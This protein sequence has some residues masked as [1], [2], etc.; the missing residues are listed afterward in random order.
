MPRGS[1][2]G[3]RRGGRHR[4][5]PNKRTVL[6]DRIL[7]AASTHPSASWHELLA[8][9]VK[10]QA[11][12]ADIRIAVARKPLPVRASRSTDTHAAR[13]SARPS[14]SGT[15]LLDLLF[16]IVQDA[17]VEPTQ[18]RKAASEAALHFLPKTPARG[19]PGAV[20]DEC[21]FVISPKMA[22]EYRDSKLQLRHLSDS[23]ASYA[24]A[25]AR[26]MAQLR[27]RIKMI[28]ERL[29]CPCPSSYG[30]TQWQNDRQ[31][32]RAL[33]QKRESKIALTEAE[34][35]DEARRMA[36]Y[37]S[38]QAG[39]EQAAKKRFRELQDKARRFKNG[40]GRRL[41][42]K[43][44]LDL[45][46]LR[47]LYSPS[48]SAFSPGLGDQ[49]YYDH[50]FSDQPFAEDGN[51]YP[52]DSHLRPAP[53]S[54]EDDDFVE[55]VDCPPYFTGNPNDPNCPEMRAWLANQKTN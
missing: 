6:T 16:S 45:R 44:R 17:T 5:T 34:D 52:P 31:R 32:V 33:A 29:E 10:D 43:E 39:P 15:P 21:D 3:E 23:P 30:D 53:S 24:L 18:R 14:T 28:L 38:L 55:F 41:T 12:P 9:L 7:A 47:L 20:A 1:K 54:P 11:L 22:I 51:L 42:R 48:L 46:L 2:P 50:P 25:Q 49:F 27:A 4:A 19:W 8:I 40:V 37:D 36:R 26:K 35:V 13:S